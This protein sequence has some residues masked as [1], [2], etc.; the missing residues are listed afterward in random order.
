MPPNIGE[1]EVVIEDTKESVQDALL[2]LTSPTNYTGN[3]SLSIPCGKAKN[4]LP[5]GVQLIAKH[6][7]EALLYQFGDALEEILGVPQILS[8]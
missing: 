8:T 5:I 3:P 1:R 4:G 6:G 7:E 2:R